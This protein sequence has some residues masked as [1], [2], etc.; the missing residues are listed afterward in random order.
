MQKHKSYTTRDYH[1]SRSVCGVL[2]TEFQIDFVHTNTTVECEV[3]V[4]RVGSTMFVY[5]LS[6]LS[7]AC[8][9]PN[10]SSELIQETVIKISSNNRIFDLR[11]LLTDTYIRVGRRITE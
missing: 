7:L 10:D 6:D 11:S 5:F 9:N 4:C 3:H 8:D 1:G 2:S